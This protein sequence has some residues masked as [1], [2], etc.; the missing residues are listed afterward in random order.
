MQI[1]RGTA[2]NLDTGG[3][4]GIR[5][6][7]GII[8][9]GFQDQ[10]F[11]PLSHLSTSIRILICVVNPLHQALNLG[12]TAQSVIWRRANKMTAYEETSVSQTTLRRY[13]RSSKLVS[14][15]LTKC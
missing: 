5:T 15:L 14:D 1:S 4:A 9:A 12:L 13:S 6:L 8:L 11:R 10:C 2:S 7:G 3:E